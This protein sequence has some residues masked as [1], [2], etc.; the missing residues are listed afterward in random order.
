MIEEEASN[1]YP[2]HDLL[3][4]RWSSRAFA[5]R[6]VEK[7]KLF[8]LLEAARWAPSSYNEQPWRFLAAI[9]E[10]P[11][12]FQCMLNCLAETNQ[13]WAKHAPVLMI[14]VAK[15]H[16]DHNGKSNRHAFHDVGLAVANLTVQAT[17]LDLF[18]H[19]MA[20]F[21]I[22]R[23]R[24]EYE[25]PEGF[26]PV[27]GLAIGYLA[28]PDQLPDSLREKELAPRVRRPIEE[29]VFAGN[30]KQRFKPE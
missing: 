15:L 17:T 6:V 5:E 27:S 3:K 2:I 20:G 13:L 8:S 19:Q 30:W 28:K 22:E 11:Q 24:H 14:A 23:T 25:I 4:K 26:E 29:F 1:D 16:F 9:K 7:D 21:D 10:E 12:E 18:V